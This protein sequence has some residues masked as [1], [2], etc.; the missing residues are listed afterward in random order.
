MKNNFYLATI[1]FFLV[2]I[3]FLSVFENNPLCAQEVQEN[4]KSEPNEIDLR[5]KMIE[6]LKE[7]MEENRI[8]YIQEHP[9][10]FNKPEPVYP[11]DVEIE[12]LILKQIEADNIRYKDRI[13]GNP[14]HGLAIS[15]ETTKNEYI[16]GEEIKISI[17][18]KNF[19]K[20][21]LALRWERGYG[22]IEDFRYAMYFNDGTPVPKSEL[23]EEYEA[24]INKPREF[25]KVGS[26]ELIYLR[27]MQICSFGNKINSYFKIEKEG[28]YYLVIMRNITGEWQDGFM[29]SNMTK[30]N[31]VK[32]K[33]E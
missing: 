14:Y 12:K 16:I 28:T 27:P 4:S 18:C 7:K 13:F 30:I 8:K 22:D 32:K 19:S 10:E 24:N 29:I 1:M 3:H 11:N 26:Y 25:P 15:I 23:I 21:K 6:K 33:E 5:N 17:L 20:T 9:E 2:A 31:I